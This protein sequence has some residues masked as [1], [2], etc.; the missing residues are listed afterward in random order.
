MLKLLNLIT[1]PDIGKT[2]ATT[3]H[4]RLRQGL[5]LLVICVR[6]KTR[7]YCTHQDAQYYGRITKDY[8]NGSDV[9]AYSIRVSGALLN[10]SGEYICSDGL[11]NY[12]RYTGVRIVGKDENQIK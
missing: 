5:D 8:N 1:C 10:E 6:A 11:D 12:D 3:I 7:E 2:G 4:W 9:A